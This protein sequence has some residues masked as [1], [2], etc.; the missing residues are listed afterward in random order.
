MFSDVFGKAATAITSR[1]LENPAEKI[2]DVSCFRTKG[3]KAINEEILDA[4]EGEL[5]VEQA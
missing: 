3:M 2:T 5:Y 1:L 4:V